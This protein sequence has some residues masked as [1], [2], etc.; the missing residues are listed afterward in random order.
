MFNYGKSAIQRHYKALK[1]TSYPNLKVRSISR[2][3][4]L[5]EFK[6]KV[7]EVYIY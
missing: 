4:N 1:D 6:D 3:I 2:P 5:T 7:I